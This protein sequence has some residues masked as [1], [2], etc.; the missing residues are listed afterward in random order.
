MAA[1]ANGRSSPGAFA[2]PLIAWNSTHRIA[3]ALGGPSTTENVRLLCRFHND[4]AAR[5]T[6]GDGMNQ[7]TRGFV[8]GD[9][10]PTSA[11]HRA[12][13]GSA[14]SPSGDSRPR[15]RAIRNEST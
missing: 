13:K 10:A 2:V 8:E 3:C 11:D 4:L 12:T 7:F 14:P 9:P 1:A 5:G 15:R 6:F